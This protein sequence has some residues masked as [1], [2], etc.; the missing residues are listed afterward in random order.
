M[1][2]LRYTPSCSDFPGANLP[3]R[4][5]AA[6]G[7]GLALPF[8]AKPAEHTLEVGQGWKERQAPPYRTQREGFLSTSLKIA[9]AVL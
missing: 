6:G 9:H 5:A 3:P 2:G 8:M 7:A 4:E 1:Q